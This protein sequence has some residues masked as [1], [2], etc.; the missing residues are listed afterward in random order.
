MIG[1]P[2]GA[3][4]GHI[5]ILQGEGEAGGL[6][7]SLHAERAPW[8]VSAYDALQALARLTAARPAPRTTVRLSVDVARALDAERRTALAADLVR[9]GELEAFTLQSSDTPWFGADLL[10]DAAAQSALETLG[11]VLGDGLPRLTERIGEVSAATGLVPATTVAAWGEQLVMLGGIRG[12]LDLFQPMI[13]ERTAADLVAATGTKQWREQ[14]YGQPP[15]R[16]EG[17]KS[18]GFRYWT[19]VENPFS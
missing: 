17:T 19:R 7:L 2:V 16:F 9:A 12:A 13:F 18:A 3:E 5:S 10:T 15:I 8:G 4:H 11:R 6:H 1:D 14:Q